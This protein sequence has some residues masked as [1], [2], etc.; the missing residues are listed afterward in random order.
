MDKRLS[1][2]KG[3]TGGIVFTDTI[4]KSPSG[5]ILRRMIRDPYKERPAVTS[6]LWS[7]SVDLVTLKEGSNEWQWPEL[8]DHQCRKM[9]STYT[10]HDA[11]MLYILQS[12]LATYLK[13]SKCNCALWY[14]VHTRTYTPWSGSHHKANSYESG[15][16]PA[17][18]GR[19]SNTNL[20]SYASLPIHPLW[21]NHDSFVRSPEP[22][23]GSQLLALRLTVG[24][25]INQK[26]CRTVRTVMYVYV[27]CKNHR[28]RDLD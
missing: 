26:M 19:S 16:A 9:H 17:F 24:D 23:P 8:V 25:Q 27:R 3:L 12:F 28:L 18:L 5:K 22:Y 7:L 6:R 14:N 2:H 4:P 13:R 20:V 21:M 15:N 11:L 10:E 1:N